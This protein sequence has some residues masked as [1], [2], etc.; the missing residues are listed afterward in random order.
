MR[1]TALDPHDAEKNVYDDY[2]DFYYLNKVNLFK[3]LV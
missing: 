1:L 3:I 2:E